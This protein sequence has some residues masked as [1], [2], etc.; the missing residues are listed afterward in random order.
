MSS[1]T[2]NLIV[3]VN[4]INGDLCSGLSDSFSLLSCSS[5]KN[6]IFNRGHLLTWWD[7]GRLRQQE[8]IVGFW[9][10]GRQSEDLEFWGRASKGN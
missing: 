5:L 8:N 6:I 10:V 7:K 3:I 1:A 2:S 4:S 9:S